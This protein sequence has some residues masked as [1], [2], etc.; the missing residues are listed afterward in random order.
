MRHAL[1]AVRTGVLAGA[2]LMVVGA[3][4]GAR[5]EAQLLGQTG[6]EAYELRDT[7]TGALARIVPGAGSECTV[8]RLPGPDGTLRDLLPALP[9]GKG[10]GYSA[11]QGIPVLFP[12]PGRIAGNEYEFE[13]KRYRLPTGRHSVAMHGLVQFRRWRV[14]KSFADENSARLTC[15]IDSTDCP[16]A[17]KGFP[18]E[19]ALRVTHELSSDGL[20]IRAYV[21]NPGDGPLPFGFGLHPWFRVPIG[22]TSKPEECTFRVPARRLWNMPAIEELTAT[23]TTLPSA[24]WRVQPE[25]GEDVGRQMSVGRRPTVVYTDLQ[26]TNGVVESHVADAKAGVRMVMQSDANMATMVVFT[27]RDGRA[28]C[29]EPWTCPPNVFNAA[30]NAVPQNG[31]IVLAPGEKWETWARFRLDGVQS[32][33]E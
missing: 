1:R 12:W 5:F 23:S 11:N 21:A 30:T 25:A 9:E 29:L 6:S 14:E 4:G 19:W 28:I 7:R 27:P 33:A 16:D 18:F 15:R 22:E 2:I 31:L 26:E 20:T 10:A 3:A 17:A 32:A 24:A 8:L 13:G